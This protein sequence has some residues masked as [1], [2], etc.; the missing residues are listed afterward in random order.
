MARRASLGLALL[1]GAIAGGGAET[2]IAQSRACEPTQAARDGWTASF[3]AGCR[4]RGGRF[5]GGSQIIHLVP[6]KGS[7][8][9]ANGYWMDNHNVWYGGSNP[10][11]G[12]SQVLRLSAPSEPWSV[13]FELG[14]RHLRT[15]LLKSVTVTQD[16]SGRP[17]PAPETLLIAATY[18]GSGAGG[19]GLF[20]RNDQTGAWTRS[21]IISGNTGR[22]GEDNSVRAAAVYRDRVTGR[23][24]LFVSVGVLGL[25][26]GQYDATHHTF[27]W[28][29]APEFG[30]TATRTLAIVE[31][32]DGLFFAAGAQIF[33]RVDGPSP[34]WMP[35]ADLSGEVDASTNRATFQS[36]GGIRGLSAIQGPVAGKQSLIFVW[37]RGSNSQGCIFRLDPQP[38]GSYT[39]LI[40]TCLSE[41]I[42]RHLDGARV[43]YA[44][45]AYSEFTP[46]TDPATGTPWHLIGLET[47][48]TGAASLPLTARNQ[49]TA[50]GG[51]YA[52]ALYAMRDPLA[53]WRIGDAN[54]RY[55]PGQPELVAIYTAALS[56]FAAAARRTIY[57]GGYDPNHHPSTDTGW[58]YATDLARLFATP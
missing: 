6:H 30:P 20:V 16:S 19:V 7:L 34:R 23:E 52:G 24:Q 22:N 12:W 28:S 44:F 56:P 49:R 37:N 21:N 5:A 50:N 35:V 41:L 26:T 17:L 4:D 29:S 33:R 46:L 51:F 3:V 10:N 58:V 2:A 53:H 13:D 40:E 9:A 8:Y 48:L 27:V 14:P 47:F 25:F 45:G 36:I 1:I 55:R 18:D 11:F 38:T 57:L 31:T 15:E 32:N 39:R 42:S 54:G 43:H